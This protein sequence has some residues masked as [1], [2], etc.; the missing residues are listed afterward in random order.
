LDVAADHPV[1]A[2]MSTQTV[3]GLPDWAQVLAQECP[4]YQFAPCA[5]FRGRSVAAVRMTPGSGVDVVIT[6]EEAEMRQALGLVESRRN[7][8]PGDTAADKACPAKPRLGDD[9]DCLDYP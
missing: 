6:S 7:A 4:G 9:P 8:H 3:N 1:V 2:V 5:V